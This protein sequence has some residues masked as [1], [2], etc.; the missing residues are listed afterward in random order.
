M[1][2]GSIFLALNHRLA[3]FARTIA[4]S[5]ADFLASGQNGEGNRTLNGI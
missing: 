3:V 4:F 2:V 1:T 5:F